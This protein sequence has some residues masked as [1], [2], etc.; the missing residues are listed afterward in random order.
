MAPNIHESM[1]HFIIIPIGAVLCSA[2]TLPAQE[3][4]RATNATPE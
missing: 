2:L 3:R 4:M 1:N